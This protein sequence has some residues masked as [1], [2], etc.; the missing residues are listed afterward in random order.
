MQSPDTTQLYFKGVQIPCPNCGEALDW[1]DLMVTSIRENGWPLGVFAL[2]GAQSTWNMIM[3]Y[4]NRSTQLRLAEM[5]IPDDA[6]VLDINYTTQDDGGL[7][8]VESH[9]NDPHRL[10]H[11]IRS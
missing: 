2:I 1:W 11:E 5:G 9:G 3:L 6:K 4:P 8:A 7:V 10:R